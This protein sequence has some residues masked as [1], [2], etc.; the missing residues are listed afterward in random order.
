MIHKSSVIDQQAKIPN[1]V[2]DDDVTFC[3]SLAK[4]GVITTPAT[5]LGSDE[6]NYFR[7]SLTQ[8]EERTAKAMEI[9]KNF[10]NSKK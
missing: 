10:L 9:L 7:L 2:K 3:L 5:W 6:N 8:N 1:N 4:E